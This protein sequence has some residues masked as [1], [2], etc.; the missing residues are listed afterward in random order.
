MIELFFQR[1]ATGMSMCEYSALQL[2]VEQT[3]KKLS[4]DSIHLK[5]EGGAEVL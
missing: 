4:I 5:T 1:K 2:P 3:L